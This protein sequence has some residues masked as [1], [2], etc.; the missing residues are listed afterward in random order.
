HPLRRHRRVRER[1]DRAAARPGGEEARLRRHLAQ[2]GALRP[3]PHLPESGRGG[4]L[5]SGLAVAA[6]VLCGCP[7]GAKP[8]PELTARGYSALELPSAGVPFA[9]AELTGKV[10]LVDFFATW[11][12]PCMA[13]LPVLE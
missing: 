5:V 1:Q 3:V 7:R 10:V 8:D 11:C 13:E 9:R 2:D 12:F 4:A 6:L